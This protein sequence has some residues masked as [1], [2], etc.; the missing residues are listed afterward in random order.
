MNN[1]YGKI[2]D[3]HTHI[4]PEKIAEKATASIGNFYGLAMASTGLKNKL[5]EEMKRA[6]VR[7]CFLL[8]TATTKNQ[9]R[10]INDFLI[11]TIKDNDDKFTAFGTIHIET[12]DPI[13]EIDRIRKNGVTGI[14]FHNDFQ[15]FAIDDPRIFPVYEKAQAEKIPIMFHAGDKRY[16]FSNPDKFVKLSKLFPD[17]I[18]I[19]SHF[20][21]YSEWDKIDDEYLATK[22]YFDTSSSF[23]SLPIEKAREMIK[24]HCEDRF[25]FGSDFPMWFASD[26]L[27]YIEQLG[28]SD[29]ITE[30][31]LFGNAEELL[32]RVKQ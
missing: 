30:K 24:K 23:F 3:V 10:A 18:V 25:L 26:E 7:H 1:Y 13:A 22:H 6:G 27:K 9:V 4:F 14:K 12:E 32:K 16:R 2:I 20:G 15:Q 29:E 31:I 21:A 11:D 19:A 28:F 17:L 8:S 5:E